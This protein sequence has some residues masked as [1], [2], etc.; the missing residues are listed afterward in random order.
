MSGHTPGPWVWTTMRGDQRNPLWVLKSPANDVILTVK[1]LEFGPTT[2]PDMNRALLAA[3]P[4]LLDAALN[5]LD[6]DECALDHEGFCQ[7]HGV[8]KPCRQQTLRSAVRKAR[9]LDK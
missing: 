7:P 9:G 1:D 4:E 2:N 6:G 3:A 5:Y 8:S